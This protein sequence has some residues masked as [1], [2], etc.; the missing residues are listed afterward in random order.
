MNGEEVPECI[1]LVGVAAGPEVD[2]VSETDGLDVTALPLGPDYPAGLLVM[3]DDQN[4]GFTINFKLID[5]AAI[6]AGLP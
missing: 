2:G 5:W 1:A 3:M 4:A 6:A